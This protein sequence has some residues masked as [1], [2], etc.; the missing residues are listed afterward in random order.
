MPVA[1]RM[2]REMQVPHFVVQSSSAWFR[3]AAA[4]DCSAVLV[5]LKQWEFL[6]SRG[7]FTRP[8]RA[9]PEPKRRGREAA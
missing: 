7:Q 8:V 4:E 3:T 1:L 9:C 6:G 2:M 5:L